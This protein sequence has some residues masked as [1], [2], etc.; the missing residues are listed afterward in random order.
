LELIAPGK[1]LIPKVERELLQELRHLGGQ[2]AMAVIV[3]VLVLLGLILLVLAAFG[4][5]HPRVSFLAAGLFCLWL[6]WALTG[7]IRLPA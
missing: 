5:N 6:A 2:K 3:L 7:P 1:R 4:V